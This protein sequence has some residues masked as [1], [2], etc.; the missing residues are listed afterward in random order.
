M[1]IHTPLLAASLVALGGSTFAQSAAPTSQQAGTH[2]HFLSNSSK[3]LGTAVRNDSDK[4]LGEIGDLLVDPRSGE[5]RYAV[6]EVGGFLGVG[7]EQRIVPWSFI[8][9]SADEKDV[10]KC[11]AR[12]NLTE[13]QVKAAPKARSGQR[14][15]AELDRRIESTF[16]KD[17]AWAYAGKGTPSFA[18]LSQMDGV[19]LKDKEGKEIGAVEEVILAPQNGC[20]AYA[21]VDMSKE[22]GDKDLALPFSQLLFRYDRNDML[23]AVTSVEAARFASAPEY[24]SK[25]W[26]RMSSTSWMT[27]LS[28]YYACDPF[29][30]SSRFA[31]PRKLPAQGS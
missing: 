23:E 15:D 5:I 25:D 11:H 2:P 20:V 21:V 6:I 12:T 27:E 16:G 1:K 8:Q 24:D 17:D 10:E 29:W 19:L 9:I 13:A 22:A 28:T 7:E 3:V 26:K 18:W 31:T 14:Y 4:N 30:K